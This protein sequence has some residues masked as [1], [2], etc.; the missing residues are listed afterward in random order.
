MEKETIAF[1]KK[2]VIGFGLPKHFMST[3]CQSRNNNLSNERLVGNIHIKKN[4]P[5][6]V[7][8]KNTQNLIIEHI[9]DFVHIHHLFCQF[10]LMELDEQCD[11][12]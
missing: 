11:D 5:K 1:M 4:R 2:M 6:A 7:F 9:R 3:S 12:L 8:N 10:D